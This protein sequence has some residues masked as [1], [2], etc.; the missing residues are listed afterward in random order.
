MTVAPR[1]RTLRNSGDLEQVADVVAFLCR[2]E[3]HLTRTADYLTGNADA[4]NAAIESRGK[5]EVILGKVRAGPTPTIH[6]WCDM[7]SSSIS[8]F[9]RGRR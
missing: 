1:W 3:Y 5:L 8:S 6:L 9:E 2:E 7:A 4:I